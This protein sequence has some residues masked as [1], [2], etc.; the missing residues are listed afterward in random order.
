VVEV[1]LARVV[2]AKAAVLHPV[3]P[4]DGGR[5]STE[6]ASIGAE[7]TSTDAAA[8]SIAAMG[9]RRRDPVHSGRSVDRGRRKGVAL[10]GVVSGSVMR[11]A[12]RTTGGRCPIGR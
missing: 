6:A 8:A 3:R 12:V 9:L 7:A 10:S 1:G 2:L 5:A 4:H 11:G